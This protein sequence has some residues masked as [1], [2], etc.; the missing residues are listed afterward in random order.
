MSNKTDEIKNFFDSWN[1]YKRII[2]FNY[3]GHRELILTLQDF[4][5]ENHFSAYSILDLGCGDSYIPSKILKGTNV[6]RYHGIDLS[7]IAL[8]FAKKNMK[9]ILCEKEFIEG[10]MLEEIDYLN[11]DKGYDIIIA[12]F[13]IHHFNL[14]HKEK[15]MNKSMHILNPKGK[16]L[17]YDEIL[18]NEETRD[19]YIQRLMN[20]CQTD[21]FEMTK[22]EVSSIQKHAS[23]SDYP[24][25]FETL[26]SIGHKYNFE[27]INSLFKDKSN[28]YELICFSR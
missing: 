5:E 23:Y 1:I 14:N 10:N 19:E 25:S 24:E 17:I 18:S 16:F 8:D 13:S 21:W 3:M 27:K 7:P 26:K 12:S 11:K 15:I 2:Q 4:I 6:I 20:I 9:T 28:L 22:E